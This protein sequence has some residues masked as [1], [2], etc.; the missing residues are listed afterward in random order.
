MRACT[1]VVVEI[2]FNDSTN[3]EE[4]YAADVHYITTQEWALEFETLKRDIM[5]DLEDDALGDDQSIEAKTASDKLKV[6]YPGMDVKK[7]LGMTTEQ[8]G[9]VRDLSTI[10]GQTVMIRESTAKSFSQKINDIIGSTGE[11]DQA[12]CWPF[13]QVVKVRLKAP[14]LQN[15]LVLVDLPGQ[16]DYNVAR[17]RVSESYIRKL[18]HIWV[19]AKIDRAVDESIARNLLGS[20]FKRQLLMEDKY[21]SDFLAF[22]ATHIDNVDYNNVIQQQQGKDKLLTDVLNK[23]KQQKLALADCVKQRRALQNGLKKVNADIKSIKGLQGDV[24]SQTLHGKRKRNDMAEATDSINESS[25]HNP[26]SRLEIIQEQRKNMLEEKGTAVKRE[27]ELKANVET[28]RIQVMMEC[29]SARNRFMQNRLQHD[30]ESG[31][32]EYKQKV[33]QSRDGESSKVPVVTKGKGKQ[34]IMIL[35][36]TLLTPSR[37]TTMQLKNLLC[38]FDGLRILAEEKGMV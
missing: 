24:P 18:N 37:Y 7:I 27:G 28:L 10:L 38:I 35:L 31:L 23:Q 8:L 22:I 19:V 25:L 32:T 11:E 9:K 15:G 26:S 2:R 16:G 21:N 13:V 17:A 4:K 6:I 3:T 30:F 5:D 1:S 14:I 34:E 33:S 12:A 29:I 36:K 20:N